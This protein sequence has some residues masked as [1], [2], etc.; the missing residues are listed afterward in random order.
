MVG[1]EEAVDKVNDGL[2]GEAHEAFED[3][4]EEV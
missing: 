2:V 3:A 4:V 1:I